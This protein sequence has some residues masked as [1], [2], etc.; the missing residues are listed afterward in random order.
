MQHLVLEWVVDLASKE[1]KSTINTANYHSC[2]TRQLVDLYNLVIVS[3]Y[4]KYDIKGGKISSQSN[5][6]PKSIS[7][8]SQTYLNF[9]INNW[10]ASPSWN[11]M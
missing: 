7:L 2:F 4:K 3:I 10:N 11:H 9:L 1:G 6:F 8:L 5:D